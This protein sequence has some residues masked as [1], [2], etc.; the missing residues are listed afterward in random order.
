[1]KYIIPHLVEDGGYTRDV[2]T[3]EILFMMTNSPDDIYV[4]VA[5]DRNELTAYAI[6][7]T[8]PDRQYIWLGQAWI[9][10]GVSRKSVKQALEDIKKWAAK[11]HNIHEIRFETERSADAIARSWGFNIHGHIMNCKF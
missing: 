6:G 11:E 1:M 3:K 9:K 4:S 10:P 8:L 5:F 7:W 2:I